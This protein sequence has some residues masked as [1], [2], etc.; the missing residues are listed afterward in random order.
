MR[1]CDIVVCLFGTT[2]AISIDK[3][4]AGCDACMVARVKSLCVCGVTIISVMHCH[5]RNAQR[6]IVLVR[7]NSWHVYVCGMVVCLFGTTVA[8]SVDKGHA[9][10]DACTG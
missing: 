1:V 4:H 7:Y 10:C 8:I 3:G 5:C 2:V 9:G 6:M